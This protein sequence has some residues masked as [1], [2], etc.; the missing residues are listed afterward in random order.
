MIIYNYD[1]ILRMYK[2]HADALYEK[3]SGMTVA[4]LHQGCLAYR[5]R[6]LAMSSECHVQENE[7]LSRGVM[8]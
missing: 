5:V 1:T 7:E 4:I 8:Y 3:D 2:G 6:G